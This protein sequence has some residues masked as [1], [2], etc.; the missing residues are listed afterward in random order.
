MR[1]SLAA[2]RSCLDGAVE[3]TNGRRVGVTDLDDRDPEIIRVTSRRGQRI[4][5]Y[6]RFLRALA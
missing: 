1:R 6:R 3:F 5:L 4:M 2:L